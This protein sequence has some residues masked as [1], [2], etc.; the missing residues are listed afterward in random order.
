MEGLVT[1]LD[2]GCGSGALV[3]E[4]SA[5]GWKTYGCDLPGVVSTSDRIRE[6]ELTPYRLPFDD[7]TFD[8]VISGAVM[9]HAR[10]KVEVF[11]EIH[12][13]LR[14][15]GHAMHVFPPKWYLVREPHIKVPL[16]SWFWPRFPRPWLALWALLGVRNVFQKQMSWREAVADNERY[17]GTKLSYWTSGQYRRL[18]ERI[19]GNCAWP[20]RFYVDHAD[21]GAA[22]LAR[23]LPMKRIFAALVRETRDSFLVLRKAGPAPGN[24]DFSA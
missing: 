10:N 22:R 1:V 12:R 23:R 9:E 21:G 2:F 17:C 7:S 6:V 19:F 4:L 20:M 14:P 13:V 8:L 16:M 5:R 11:Q 15:G 3:R 24:G 18:S